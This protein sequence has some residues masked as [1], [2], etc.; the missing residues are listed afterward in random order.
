MDVLTRCTTLTCPHTL[1]PACTSSHTQLTATWRRATFVEKQETNGCSKTGGQHRHDTHLRQW[2]HAGAHK[3]TDCKPRT[4][5]CLTTRQHLHLLHN[6]YTSSQLGCHTDA[7]NHPPS[8]RQIA[9]Q[10][11]S[12]KQNLLRASQET[13]FAAGG[14]GARRQS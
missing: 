13:T 10:P 7:Q 11:A 8:Y 1:S 6:A 3:G 9:C 2:M 14:R 12:L 4:A 5:N